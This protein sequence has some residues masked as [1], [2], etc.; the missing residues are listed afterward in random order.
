MGVLTDHM[1]RLTG[2]IVSMREA[3]HTLN[4]NLAQEA[5]FRAHAVRR[6]CDNFFTE[7]TAA[8]REHKKE[9]LAFVDTIQ[10]MVSAHR[11]AVRSDLAGVR[12]A[13]AG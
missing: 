2:E 12:Q 10:R 8:A 11:N 7:R 4:R 3:R 1:T 13:W 9:R 6:M 5:T